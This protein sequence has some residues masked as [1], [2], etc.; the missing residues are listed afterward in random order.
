MILT[1]K[2]FNLFYATARIWFTLLLRTTRITCYKLLPT[3]PEI[4]DLHID[5]TFFPR[6][7]VLAKKKGEEK[8]QGK[9]KIG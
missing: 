1:P 2:V 3:T 8:E 4:V 7:G 9:K 5:L 6:C